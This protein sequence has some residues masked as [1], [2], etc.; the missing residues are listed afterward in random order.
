MGIKQTTQSPTEADLEAQINTAIKRVFFNLPS[1]SIRHQIKFKFDFGHKTIEIDGAKPFFAHAIADVI[2]FWNDTPLAVLELKRPGIKLRK[3]DGLQ[4]LS[5]ARAVFPSAPLVIVTNGDET[6]FFE[7]RTGE[8]WEAL[9]VSEKSLKTLFESVFYA[10][11]SDLRFAVDT[12]MGTNPKVWVQAI[13][14]TTESTLEELTGEFSELTQPFV[15]D[16]LIKRSATADLIEK[17]DSG[18][19]LIFVEGSS[20][21][22]KSSVLRE[23]CEHYSD[24]FKRSTLYIHN[25]GHCSIYQTIADTLEESLSWPLTLD[26]ARIWL[27]RISKSEGPELILVIDGLNKD[28]KSVQKEI[29]ELSSNMF[30]SSLKIVIALD[31]SVA[32]RLSTDKGRSKT[33]IG[34]RASIIRISRLNDEEFASAKSQLLEKDLSFIEGAQ[35]S[36]DYRRPWVIRSVSAFALHNSKFPSPISIPPLV[37]AGLITFA[38][39]RFSDIEIR[40]HFSSLATAIIKESQDNG[41]HRALKDELNLTPLVRKKI[42]RQYLSLAA[43][44]SLIEHGYLVEVIH[45]ITEEHIFYIRQPALVASEISRFMENSIIPHLLSQPEKTMN[46]MVGV[47]E[48]LP[49][50]GI[51]TAQA[52]WGAG[53]E[54]K[55]LLTKAI[56]LLKIIEPVTHQP[57]VGQEFTVFVGGGPPKTLRMIEKDVF[58]VLVKG[59]PPVIVKGTYEINDMKGDFAPWEILSHLAELEIKK[60]LDESL[61]RAE[62]ILLTIGTAL[63]PTLVGSKGSQPIKIHDISPRETVISHE[64][65]IVEQVTQSI[66]VLLKA[67][68]TRASIFLEKAVLKNST[69]LLCRIYIALLEI[70]RSAD[71]LLSKWSNDKLENIIIPALRVKAPVLFSNKISGD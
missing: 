31:T 14:K 55:E 35:F 67:D 46:W 4:G 48:H 28:S 15:R 71:L 21:S 20:L 41:L 9:E 33:T 62:E 10:S 38:R 17:L 29:K 11:R 57:N 66:W 12:L 47:V 65:G 1:D 64:S 50:G 25:D 53:V 44:E 69:P 68:T 52:L 32:T 49:L 18:D 60:G 27:K 23:L 58:E 36:S 8:R 16:F 13:R 3:E 24:S 45:H 59:Q 6:N 5:Y 37:G 54:N 2:L 40:E 39:E 34:R 7:T 26:E 70:N 56:E 63:D 51:I 43:E 19:N 42:L 22:G 61:S 30:G